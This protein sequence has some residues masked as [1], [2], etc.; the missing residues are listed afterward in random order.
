[1]RTTLIL[2]GLVGLS[3][4]PAACKKNSD[5]NAPGGEC[6]GMCGRG[7]RC[8]GNT[9]V[10]DYSQDICTSQAVVQ[11]EVPMRP[12]ITS[13]GE[14]TLDRNQLP[15]KFVPVDDKSIPQYDPNRTRTLDWSAGDEQLNE[16]VLNANMRE[17]EYAINECLAVAACYNGGSLK[18]GRIDLIISLVGKTGRADAVSVT[19]GPDLQVFGIVPCVRKA[20]ANHQFPTYN[21]PPMTVK[22]NIEIGGTE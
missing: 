4:A 16:P 19:A 1:M 22:Y 20:I 6:G 7:T 15:K 17:V 11:E 5:S 8:D 13:W 9:C 18:G 10:V 21:G 12:P 3:M 14:C 2:A